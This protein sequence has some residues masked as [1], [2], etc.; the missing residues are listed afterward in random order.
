M[1][2]SLR[3][4]PPEESSLS[5]TLAK[6]LEVPP[7]HHEDLDLSDWTDFDVPT[8]RFTSMYV[9]L[10]GRSLLKVSNAR[11]GLR[12]LAQRPM[13]DGELREAVDFL[14]HHDHEEERILNRIREMRSDLLAPISSVR[15]LAMQGEP[16]IVMVMPRLPGGLP[17]CDLALAQAML[18][19]IYLASH[20]IRHND[21]RARNVVVGPSPGVREIEAVGIRFRLPKGAPWARLVDFNRASAESGEANAD[22]RLLAADAGRVVTSTEDGLALA[23]KIIASHGLL[24]SYRN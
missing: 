18:G 24:L 15:R 17:F 1:R 14:S 10:D 7:H 6:R 13:T 21:A 16:V 2:R 12:T 11:R 3:I 23:R 20:Q 22:L 4:V 5:Q 8:S 19:I 9:S